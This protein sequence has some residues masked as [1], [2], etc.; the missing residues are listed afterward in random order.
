MRNQCFVF[1]LAALLA[2]LALP[3]TTVLAQQKEIFR[4]ERL[5][6]ET[7]INDLLSQL[8]LA[9]KVSLLG[10]E[11]KAIPG[12]QIPA[13]NWWNEA[14]HGVARAGLATV[15]PQAIGLAASFNDSLIRE[16]AGAISTEARAKYNIFTANNR[17]IQY[18]GL[19]FWSPNINIFRDPR[20][21]RGQE[22][23]GE[24]P[25][26]TAKMGLAFV[27]GMQGN[28]AKY[29]KTAACAKH[30]AVHSGPENGRHA[31]NSIVDEKDL[32]ETYLFAFKKLVDGGVESVM[33]AY[34]RTNGEPCCTSNTL[35]T[36]ILLQEWR[37]KGH[38]VTDCG[39]LYDIITGHK[40]SDDPA[41]VAAMAIRA[42]VNLDCANLLQKNV[43][44]AIQRKLLTEKE[45][46]A[47]LAKLLRTQFKLGFYDDPES[48]PFS[49]LGEADVHN[50]KNIALAKTVAE[51]SMVLL[52]ND[53]RLLP[54][55]KEAYGSIM[56]LGSNAGAMDPMVGN[57][58]GMSGNIV[59]FAEGIT[60]AAGPG[61]AVQY[62]LG[63]NFTDTTRFGGVWAAGNSDITIA[64]I[65][66]TPVYEGEEGD[67]FLAA[68]GGDRLT[69]D[70]PAAHIALLKKLKQNKKPLIAVVTAGSN[71]N[72]SA[73]EPYADAIILAW[74]PG[75]QGGNA[76]GDIL[77][78]TVSP[79][80]RLP[81]TFYNSLTDL[82]DYTSYGM[83]GRTYRYFEG[84]VQFPFGYGLSY[85]TFAYDWHYKPKAIRS[86]KDSI[87]FSV[88][89][90]N[91]GS[92]DGDEVAQV[93]IRYPAVE[94][95][96]L[97]ELKAFKRVSI[98]KGETQKIRF[99][100]PASELMKW[101]LKAKKWLLY[102]GNYQ[103]LIGSSSS[104]IRL[105]AEVK[106]K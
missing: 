71:V 81:V 96:P 84:D 91:T 1:T 85:T 28:D 34:N 14:L 65:G 24:D 18:G 15:F 95:M 22:T 31:F 88:V 61:I 19:T 59:T 90:T 53:N 33:C 77:F 97:K 3:Q 103:V 2:L 48:N 93:Y 70:L 72:I 74:Y 13:Y 87:T 63:S 55:K 9:E 102:P 47:S 64:V 37:F 54:L 99:S 68:N 20:W 26:L 105:Q 35:L 45:V 10:N 11:N 92:M 76:L 25:Y 101:D 82:P 56:V 49:K 21:G 27:Q 8:T 67:A 104:D 73:I 30:Y 106:V 39:A 86:A 66:L 79:S 78:G 29:L 41:A 42:G 40:L 5:P 62:D 94:R 80:G 4:D 17:H 60:A 16:V 7:R 100:I 58:H 43:E 57:Y 51:Q 50:A 46:D 36:N 12:L 52:K 89:V 32:R 23:Y 75:E 38:V 98:P 69:L 6:M 44:D 83:K